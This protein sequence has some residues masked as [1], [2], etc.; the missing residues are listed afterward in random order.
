M[1]RKIYHSIPI[2]LAARAW[3]KKKTPLKWQRQR[4]L[5]NF[6]TITELYFWRTDKGIDTIAPIQNYFSAL[7]PD[8]DTATTAKI[9]FYDNR[10]TLV[11]EREFALSHKGMHVVRISDIP[12]IR[13][14]H[15]T[16]MWHINMPDAVAGQT[17]VRKNLVYFTDRGYI[18]YEK[19]GSQPAFTHGVDR[20]AVFQ[21]QNLER[22]EL[23]YGN[24]SQTRSWV[25]EFP[26]VE[27]MQTETEVI[28][29]NRS[30]H[31]QQYEISVF[32]NGGALISK[33]SIDV[34]PR[35]VGIFSIDEELMR[36]LDGSSGFFAV[37]G[38]PTTWGRPAIMRH[39]SSGAISIMHC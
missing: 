33:S 28:L 1:L 13:G 11:A 27:G 32:K 23:F 5:R 30:A 18:C 38:I 6:G 29:L 16:F 26:L 22:H 12:E 24:L 19:S 15:G 8:L 39:F 17:A 10:G 31:P 36:R 21:K 2:S 4:Q 25:P 37:D 34:A 3:L 20:Y 35:G 14:S 7:F 9:W